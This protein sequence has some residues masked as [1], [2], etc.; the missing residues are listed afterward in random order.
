MVF[1]NCTILW[2]N[3]CLHSSEAVLV[4]MK[5]SLYKAIIVLTSS[6]VGLALF[7]TNRV[8]WLRL[9]S[10]GAEQHV[11]NDDSSLVKARAFD[12]WPADRPLPCP[13]KWQI[14]SSEPKTRGFLFLRPFK[15]ASSSTQSVN[16]WIA[17]NEARRQGKSSPFCRVSAGHGP[18]PYPAADAF[19]ECHPEGS[20]LW[21]II[22]DP[23]ARAVSHFFYDGVR[24]GWYKA[25]AE[26]LKEDLF[27]D[28]PPNRPHNYYVR[29]LSLHHFDLCLFTTSTII[30]TQSSFPIK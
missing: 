17:R 25:N 28:E 21:S 9:S 27:N 12:L 16:F 2:N 29:S 15:C 30:P 5:T 13:P 14:R 1:G 10:K 7:I 26:D 22:R 11:Y 8:Q 23:T 6:L 24:H 19:G 20:V 4:D 18:Q 3:P